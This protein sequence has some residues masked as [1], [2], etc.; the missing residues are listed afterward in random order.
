MWAPNTIDDSINGGTLTKIVMLSNAY[1]QLVVDR[2]VKTSNRRILSTT[3]FYED[4][5]VFEVFRRPAV[6]LVAGLV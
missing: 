1:D 6:K 2:V 5:A 4:P 3:R